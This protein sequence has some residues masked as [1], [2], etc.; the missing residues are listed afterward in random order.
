MLVDRDAYLLEVCRYVE[1]NPV[2]AGMVQAAQDWPWSSYRAHTGRVQ[3]PE[4]LDTATVLAY[5]RQRSLATKDGAAEAALR[6]AELVEQGRGVR[7]WDGAL[8]QQIF[9]GDEAFVRRMRALAEERIAAAQGEVPVDHCAQPVRPLDWYLNRPLK[10]DA[11][12]RAAHLQGRYTM[13]EI[14]RVL[15]LSVSRVSRI[16]GTGCE[17]REAATQR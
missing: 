9:L 17:R 5:V 8:R 14:A 10:R 15:G 7:L 1:L 6:Y 13:S 11:C 2:R 4:W 3:S 12:I 16:I